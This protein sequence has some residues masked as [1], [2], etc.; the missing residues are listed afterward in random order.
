M[1]TDIMQALYDSDINFK[2]KA[3]AGDGFTVKV[4][5]DY[6]CWSEAWRGNWGGVKT[7]L[8]QQALALYPHSQFAR[9]Y[10]QM[11]PKLEDEA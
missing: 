7:W 4:E 11:H 8:V 5:D 2:I 9:K 6:G 3:E 10:H 1:R